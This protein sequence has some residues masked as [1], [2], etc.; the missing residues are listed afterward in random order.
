MEESITDLIRRTCQRVPE[1]A[2]LVERAEKI[3]TELAERREEIDNLETELAA[4]KQAEEITDA[5]ADKWAKRAHA[6][7]ERVRKTRNL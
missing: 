2:A 7:E 6:A 1:F 5:E 3:E 4:L